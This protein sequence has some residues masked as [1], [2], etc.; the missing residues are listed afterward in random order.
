MSSQTI[1]PTFDVT[2]LKLEDI[3]ILQARIDNPRSLS[4]LSDDIPVNIN[5]GIDA[6]FNSE[7]KKIRLTSKCDIT[8]ELH[9]ELN[10]S[11]EIAFYFSLRDYDNLIKVEPSDNKV[12]VEENLLAAIGN[13][14]YSTSRGIIYSRCLGT[15][16]NK[17]L[18]PIV[19][20]K[21]IMDAL[22]NI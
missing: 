13:I 18:L 8:T 12:D 17:V 6:A 4:A 22:L 19:A 1:T 5:F 14:T 16:L 21:T 3:I 7:A 9:P 11:F 15:V 20:N 10:G 2:G